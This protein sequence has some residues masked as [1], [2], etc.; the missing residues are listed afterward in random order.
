MGESLE[1]IA[2]AISNHFHQEMLP[3]LQQSPLLDPLLRRD[4]NSVAINWMFLAEEVVAVAVA[5]CS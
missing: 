3:I 5:V 4:A 2:T 1:L